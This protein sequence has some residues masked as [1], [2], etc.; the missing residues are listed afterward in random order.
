VPAIPA[1]ITLLVVLYGIGGPSFWRDEGATLSAVHRSLPQLVRMLGHTDVVH[2]AYYLFMWFEVRVAG[3][4]ELAV[5]FPSAVAMAVAAGGITVLGRRLLSTRAGLAAGLVFAA[6]PG[7]SWYGQN[8][9]SYAM[10]TA[11]ATVASYLLARAVTAGPGHRRRWL[12][13]YGVALAALGLGNLFALLLIPAHA[14]TLAWWRRAGHAAAAAGQ[15][16]TAGRRPAAAGSQPATAGGQPAPG[17]DRLLRRGWLAAAG[18]A[19]LV[20]SPV[21]VIS[22]SQRSQVSWLK[23]PG[24]HALISLG[25]IIGPPLVSGLLVVLTLVLLAV[26]VMRG[27]RRTDWPAPLLA[28]SLPW[29]V[30][31]PAML[32][33][34]SV[35]HPAYSVRYIVFCAPAAALL[36]GAG[37]ASLGW[38][39]GATVLAV[40]VLTAVPGQVNARRAGSH[41][42]NLRFL[43]RIL[44]TYGRPGDA[45]LFAG[46]NDREFAAAYPAGYRR[47]RDVGLGQHAAQAGTLLD[48]EAPTPVIRSRLDT[49]TRLWA[50]ETGSQR[51]HVPILAGLN[52]RESHRWVVSGI[53]LVL[54]THRHH[55]G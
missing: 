40:V 9:R 4:S 49:V 43:S 51:G 46:R 8:A 18:S 31:P 48:T 33:A 20:A 38:A 32:L 53:W 22:W 1:V 15:P 29:L 35:V 17:P 44:V 50:V 54:Y 3:S 11:L 7:V 45:L 24:T 34:V 47:L 12:A 26:S 30:L 37:L 16:A 6:L 42:E 13:G 55:P 5:R 19:L 25:Q 2:G 14:L 36:V 52:F 23:K 39:A 41:G 28:L 27:R 21:A 10:V